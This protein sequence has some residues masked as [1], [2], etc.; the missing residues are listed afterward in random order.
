MQEKN[1]KYNTDDL[2]KQADAKFEEML[3]EGKYRE[4]ID[5]MISLGDYSLRNQMLILAAN[6]NATHV[7][8]MNAWNYRKRSIK[9]GEKSIKILAP[10][11]GKEV[12]FDKDGQP[13]ETVLNKV[14]GYRVNFVFDESQTQGEDVRD[15]RATP[16]LLDENYDFVTD[17]LKGTIKGFDFSESDALGTEV[18]SRLDTE[19]RTIEISSTLEREA[20]IKT[21]INQIAAAN[22][23]TRD[24]RN[25]NGLQ[26]SEMNSVEMSA[27]TYI[28]ANRLG[29]KTE[30]LIEPDFSKFGDK[31]YEKF[32]GNIGVIRS[33]SQKMIMAVENKLSYELHRQQEAA[34]AA[35]GES[36]PAT[37][38]VTDVKPVKTEVK[39]VPSSKSR[40]KTEVT[41]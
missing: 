23:L 21:L 22:V 30:K 4:L 20:K 1:P 16:A 37:P 9:P 19:S 31:D 33:V 11:F 26:S 2:I 39:K 10:V 35:E 17:V 27:I 6:P 40:K 7:E 12:V 18:T 8:G 13:T 36:A 29:L 5:A 25:F 3:R 14:T 34:K 41:M 38:E 28:V 15:F 24:R 32:A